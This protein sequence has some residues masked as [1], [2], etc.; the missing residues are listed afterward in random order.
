MEIFTVYTSPLSLSHLVQVFILQNSMELHWPRTPVN[1]SL[2]NQWSI[3]VW[4]THQQKSSQSMALS[5][6][7]LSLTGLCSVTQGSSFTPLG[8][9]S[10]LLLLTLTSEAWKTQG[11]RPQF[12]PLLHAHLLRVGLPFCAMTLNVICMAMT[13][14]L[15]S[16][17]MT[18]PTNS[19]LLYPTATQQNHLD[20]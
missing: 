6:R 19:S 20:V 4:P 18:S 2:P 7:P 11:L 16:L 8:T 9:F 15:I 17:R 1:S 3:L 10:W 5:S 12:F 13:S 14:N